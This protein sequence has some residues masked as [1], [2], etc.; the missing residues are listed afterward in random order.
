[1]QISQ[2]RLY[3]NVERILEP[4][5]NGTWRT[6]GID[7]SNVAMKL[8][9]IGDTREPS[10]VYME[11]YGIKDEYLRIPPAVHSEMATIEGRYR[12]HVA[13]LEAKIA[14]EAEGFTIDL[15]GRAGTVKHRLTSLAEGVWRTEYDPRALATGGFL[16]F[17]HPNG[18]SFSNCLIYPLLFSPADS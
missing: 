2:W 4:S 6:P 16:S 13:S 1:M 8:T 5:E 15:A 9:P 17:D 12:S 11:R 14:R 10:A 7:F 18:F 3:R